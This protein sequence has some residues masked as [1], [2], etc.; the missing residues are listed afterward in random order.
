MYYHFSPKK[1]RKRKRKRKRKLSRT[2]GD[3]VERFLW[4]G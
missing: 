4:E 2:F 1:K 3:A